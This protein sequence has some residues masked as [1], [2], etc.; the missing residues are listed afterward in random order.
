[1]TVP[2]LNEICAYLLEVTGLPSERAHHPWA[3]LSLT[4]QAEPEQPI[5]YGILRTELELNL[6]HG[7][8]QS[9]TPHML[10][11]AYLAEGEQQEEACSCE[12]H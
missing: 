11:E 12:V 2:Q 1:M 9:L 8:I 3:M 4:A 5:M 7:F 10:L 6:D